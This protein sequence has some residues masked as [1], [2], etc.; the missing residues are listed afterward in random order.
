M[1]QAF[2]DLPNCLLAVLLLVLIVGAA[3]GGLLVG[4]SFRTR[5]ESGRETFGVL[6][7]A[8]IG[9]MGLILAFGLSLA[10]ERYECH[11]AAVVDDANTIGTAYLRDPGRAPAEPIASAARAV[12]RCRTQA[13]RHRAGKC[14]IQAGDRGGVAIDDRVDTCRGQRRDR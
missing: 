9:F 12:Y 6:Q 13:V 14:R 10:V 1:G 11:R 3:V 8:L 4:R 5:E 2:F 7:A